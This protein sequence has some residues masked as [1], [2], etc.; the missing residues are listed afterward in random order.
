MSKLVEIKS[1]IEKLPRLQKQKQN[2]AKV[3]A[4]R[5]G[6][7]NAFT[8]LGDCIKQRNC[9]LAVFPDA[10]LRKTEDAVKQSRKQAAR[11]VEKLKT[12]FDEIGSR[13]TDNKI[14][15]IKER[16]EEAGDQIRKD[17]KK[18]VVDELKPLLPLVDIVREATL[19]GHEEISE[20]V[21]AIK[22]QEESPPETMEAAVK[23]RQSLSFLRESL[24]NLDLE[25]PGGEFLKKAVKGKA[26]AKDL[27]KEEVQSFLNDKDLW[28]ILTINVG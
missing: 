15:R 24:S 27:L 28:D 9:F 16:N 21:A 25:G 4:F 14:T 11:L 10:K 19:P 18:R 6:I 22:A 23:M 3:E 8:D 7:N 12:D 26:S 17:W 20:S 5:I 2:N 1:R 13:E